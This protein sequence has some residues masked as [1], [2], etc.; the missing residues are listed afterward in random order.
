[1]VATRPAT[2]RPDP[3]VQTLVSDAAQRLGLSNDDFVAQ[4]VRAYLQ[5]RSEERTAKMRHVM[6]KLDGTDRARV[7]LLTGL[8]AERIEQLGGTG[9]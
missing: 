8:S 2:W 4:A 1:M 3:A 9:E 7:A 5:A 6:G